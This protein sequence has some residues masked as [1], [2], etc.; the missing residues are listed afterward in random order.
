MNLQYDINNLRN[1]DTK[2][3]QFKLDKKIL[4]DKL[5]NWTC[6]QPDV[7]RED[8]ND[9]VINSLHFLDIIKNRE[10]AEEFAKIANIHSKTSLDKIL[11]LLFTFLDARHNSSTYS[12]ATYEWLPII[13][14]QLLSGHAT[15]L[16]LSKEPPPG[17]AMIAY[18]DNDNNLYLFD[19]QQYTLY[20]E[21]TFDDYFKVYTMLTL[22]YTSNK[23]VLSATRNVIRKNKNERPAK[24]TRRSSPPIS[25]Q[26]LNIALNK[27][28]LNNITINIRKSKH[29]R[30]SKRTRR[31]LTPPISQKKPV[32]EL[33]KRKL[34][35]TTIKIRK[36]KNEPPIKQ[37]QRS[38]T[39]PKN[40]TN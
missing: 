39:P 18:K 22:L 6:L 34:N 40:P 23:R 2:L 9:C 7:H 10:L 26:K 12:T 4:E 29:E 30:P 17:H 13:K 8:A 35:N 25:P 15:L 38:H 31:S 36:S 33:R 24:R 27:R 14:K 21:D 32:I 19:P 3:L 11:D 20:N 1:Q 37:S 28:K 16:L 5:N